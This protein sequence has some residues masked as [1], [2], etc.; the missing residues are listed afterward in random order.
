MENLTLGL[1]LSHLQDFK[2]HIFTRCC[3]SLWHGN[4]PFYPPKAYPLTYPAS[5]GYYFEVTFIGWVILPKSVSWVWPQAPKLWSFKTAHMS[6]VHLTHHVSH[7]YLFKISWSQFRMYLQTHR[8]QSLLVYFIGR[9]SRNASH[10]SCLCF[11][12]KVNTDRSMIA[13]EKLSFVQVLEVNQ[14]V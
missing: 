14:H 4:S 1:R 10:Q 13:N 2:D 5:T 11:G 12:Y 8:Q 7:H 9:K 3:F 6:F